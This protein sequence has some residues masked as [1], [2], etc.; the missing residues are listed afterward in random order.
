MKF[1]EHR[2][3]YPPRPKNAIESSDLQSYDDGSMISQ[4]KSNG[5]NCVFSTNGEEFHAMNRHGDRLSNFRI[6]EDELKGIY[7]GTGEWMVINGEYLNKNKSDE[8]NQSFNHKLI[9]FDILVNDGDYLVGRTFED[10]ISI[11]DE[12]YGKA[13]SDKEYLY[14]I[15]ENVYRVKSYNSGF[16]ELFDRYVPIDL[17][18]GLVLKRKNSKLEISNGVDNN[19]RSQVKCRKRCNSYKY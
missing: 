7:R 10:R 9:I 16:K 3:I 14:K 15:S 2:F 4:I 1:S 18:E 11:L 12:L 6:T 19:W 13:N 8:T 17:V 5:S